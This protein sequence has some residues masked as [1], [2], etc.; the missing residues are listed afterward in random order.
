MPPRDPTVSPLLV[1][2]RGTGAE[3]PL[4]LLPP[5]G[6]HALWCTD[7]AR[8]LRTS[9]PVWAFVA[10]EQIDGHGSPETVDA[11]VAGYVAELI[12][13]LPDTPVF[14]VGGYSL[15]STL[16]VETARQL[17]AAGRRVEGVVLLGGALVKAGE[18]NDARA[19]SGEIARQLGVPP[20]MMAEFEK[21]GFEGVM[22]FFAMRV[23]AV[24]PDAP[25]DLGAR[26]TASAK[27]SVARAMC[28]TP[29]PVGV[30]LALLRPEHGDPAADGE[31]AAL[32]EGPFE[33]VSVPGDHASM[34]RAPHA[35]ALARHVEA[36][37][38]A[39]A[40]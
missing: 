14:R 16:A 25:E 10:P 3:P 26:M 15:G 20:A 19:I 29:R 39:W 18:A 28:W 1:P 4:V 7:L 27:G 13:T 9:V 40:R 5:I 24:T 8:A 6:G 30:P 17:V 36:V 38:D 34:I 21:R 23:R 22:H 11:L 35:D 12:D 2:L 37:L 33:V 31:W 32:A